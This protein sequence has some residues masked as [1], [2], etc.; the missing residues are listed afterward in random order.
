MEHLERSSKVFWTLTQTFISSK[1]VK[2]QRNL[3]IRNISNGQTITCGLATLKTK[4]LAYLQD[5]ILDL[6]N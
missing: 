4:D 5:L 6:K 1:N 2:I 3:D